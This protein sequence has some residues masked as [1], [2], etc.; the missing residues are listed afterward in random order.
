MTRFDDPGLDSALRSLDA[1]AA[2]ISPVEQ[3]RAGAVLER[4]VASAGT[5]PPAPAPPVAPVRPRGSRPGRPGLLLPAAAIAVVA[6]SVL[7]QG[8]RPDDMDLTSWTASPGAVTPAELELL[9]PP[10]RDQLAGGS[11][12]MGRARLVLSER[13]GDFVVLLYRTDDPDM[14]GTCLIRNAPGATDVDVSSGAGGSDG[15]A[16]QAP[17]TGFTEGAISQFREASVTDGAVGARVAAVTIHAGTVSV[18][19]SV[20]NGRYA[21]W[22]PGWVFADG[23]ARPDGE[24]GFPPILTYDLTLVDG[25]VL[26]DARPTR[27]S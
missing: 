12:D 15:P 19:A 21:A 26:R 24:E 14:S 2:A 9:A 10:C 3:Q 25:T 18:R 13:R 7:A 6:G 4:I 8:M 1:A 23:P 5:A 20:Q 22:W 17:P 11:L 27:P 16:Q